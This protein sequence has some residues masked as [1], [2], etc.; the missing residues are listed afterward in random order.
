MSQPLYPVD[1]KFAEHARYTR[2]QYLQQYNESISD[3]DSFWALAGQR[4]DWIKPYTKIKDVSYQQDDFRIRWFYDGQLNVSTNC[5]D[6]HLGTRDHKTAIIWEG[7]S[8]EESRHI[9]YRE[10]YE[11]VCQRLPLACWP[12][13]VSARF[14]RWSLVDF[15]PIHL[16][17]ELSIVSRVL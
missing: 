2:N 16:Q 4:L 14:I 6:R 9:T 8:P 3:P 1:R 12:V 13:R 11:R 10:L 5:L 17:V 15:H 7:D